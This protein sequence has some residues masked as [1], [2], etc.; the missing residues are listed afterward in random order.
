MAKQQTPETA[1]RFILS[2]LGDRR[3]QFVLFVMI[4]LSIF[5]W[6]LGG[7]IQI[8]N[9]D[10]EKN[11]E[12]YQLGYEIGVDKA[13]YRKEGIFNSKPGE[14]YRLTFNI[15]SQYLSSDLISLA[16]KNKPISKETSIKVVVTNQFGDRS[17]VGEVKPMSGISS[18][19]KNELYFIADGE[20]RNISFEKEDRSE[21]LE[22]AIKDIGLQRLYT[23]DFKLLKPSSIGY[24]DQS[25]QLVKSKIEEPQKIYDY[26]S[27]NKTVGQIIKAKSDY[28]SNVELKMKFLGNGGNNGYQLVVREVENKNNKYVVKPGNLAEFSF[29]AEMSEKAFQ[30]D[31]DNG[32]YRFPITAKTQK[33]SYYFVGISSKGVKVNLLNHLQLFGSKAEL[34]QDGGFAAEV[35]S[36]GNTK[37]IGSLYFNVYGGSLDKFVANQMLFGSFIED[38]GNGSGIFSYTKDSRLSMLD[39]I[40]SSESNVL[41]KIPIPYTFTALNLRA[42]LDTSNLLDCKVSYSFDGTNWQEI[43]EDYDKANDQY[44]LLLKDSHA[45]GVLYLK[46]EARLSSKFKKQIENDGTNFKIDF[47]KLSIDAKLLIK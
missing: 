3:Y 35:D 42:S 6:R 39:I 33:D 2:V 27:D 20:Y 8:D 41:Y 40:S 7:N 14:G 34:D 23:A 28:I 1:K 17:V 47:S 11:Q 10:V 29:G 5:G 46:V 45:P 37:K 15:K 43:T 19:T 21:G 12:K 13:S 18:F 26:Y 16:D 25:E 9:S 22:V 38:L 44:A 4:L 36:Q 30:V 31:T 32:I 24:M